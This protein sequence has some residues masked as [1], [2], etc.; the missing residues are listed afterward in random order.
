MSSDVQIPLLGGASPYLDARPTPC[1]FRYFFGRDLRKG[2][3]KFSQISVPARLRLRFP[4]YLNLG[5][6]G[7]IRSARD[8][9]GLVGNGLGMG[10]EILGND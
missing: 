9:L 2:E 5:C 3:D 1:G 6:D 8:D 10:G 4:S 7:L